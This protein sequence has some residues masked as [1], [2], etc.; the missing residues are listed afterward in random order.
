MI[1]GPLHISLIILNCILFGY[2]KEQLR[3]GSNI[4]EHSWNH[5]A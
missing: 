3:R 1:I 2:G 5:I 4:L